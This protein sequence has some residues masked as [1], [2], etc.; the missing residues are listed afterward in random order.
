MGP[1]LVKSGS[2]HHSLAEKKEKLLSMKG[3]GYSQLGIGMQ[4]EEQSKMVKCWKRVKLVAH[5]A[6]DMGRSDPRK[7]VFAAKMG[8]ALTLIS[9]LIFLKEPF[10]DITRNSVWAILTVVVVFEFSIGTNQNYKLL[11]I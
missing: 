5:K 8:L 6:W 10:K 7:I 3:D 2:F 9:L 4:E 11:I 1:K